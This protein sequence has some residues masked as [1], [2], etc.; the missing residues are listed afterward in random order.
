M[1]LRFGVASGSRQQTI[2]GSSL[3]DLPKCPKA[4]VLNFVDKADRYIDTR[5]RNVNVNDKSICTWSK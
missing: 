2:A 3:E 1:L 5:Q 4:S